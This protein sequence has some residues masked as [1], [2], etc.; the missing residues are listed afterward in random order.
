[1][2]CPP[3][4]SCARHELREKIMKVIESCIEHYALIYEGLLKR[5]S[6]ENNQ[7]VPPCASA[8]CYRRAY[9]LYNNIVDSAGTN[10][11]NYKLKIKEFQDYVTE[12]SNHLYDVL[13]E[14]NEKVQCPE[15]KEYL[16]KN[17]PINSIYLLNWILQNADESILKK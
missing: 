8:A 6:R 4:N 17:K 10:P 16:E 9:D 3:L 5:V 13:V 14:N 15:L 1:M 11:Q 2:R 7:K 12:I